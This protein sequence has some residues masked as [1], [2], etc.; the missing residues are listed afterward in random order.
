MCLDNNVRPDAYLHE[1]IGQGHED[2][3]MGWYVEQDR[4]DRVQVCLDYI[5]ARVKYLK[6]MYP[7]SAITV[8]SETK[9]DPGAI[10]GR[11]DWWG[12]CDITITVKNAHGKAL[13]IEVIDYKDGK[14]FVPAKG[15]DQLIS[16]LGGKIEPYLDSG[17]RIQ[18]AHPCQVT[19]VQPKTSPP[20]RSHVYT[21]D[22]LLTELKRLGDAAELTDDPDAPLIPDDKGGKGYCF[23]CNH[24]PNCTALAERDVKELESMSTELI[25]S[26]GGDLF[27][28][29]SELTADPSSMSNEKLTKLLDAEPGV[30]SV[31]DRAR[32]EIE[33]R[34]LRGDDVPGW[35]IGY[36][37][38]S[39]VWAEDEEVVATKL[40][41]QRLKKDDIYPPK[42]I[43][44]AAYLK[45]PQLKPEQK[46]RIEKELIVTKAGKEKVVR[47]AQKEKQTGQEMFGEYVS[48]MDF[49]KP[50]APAPLDFSRPQG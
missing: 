7:G 5:T 6:D 47:V 44:P 1:V 2:N 42:L 31:F 36:G 14:R 15:K 13:F 11:D 23:F 20:V 48:K 35:G 18:V 38:A 50:A 34:V 21:H 22:E 16:Y 29:S 46:A 27:S 30:M 19:I 28:L 32:Q 41:S 24:K 3:P 9:S 26:D 17:F 43:T 8:E 10:F 37:N 33:T 12:T 39:K 49:S 40:K 45:L 25:T 4:I